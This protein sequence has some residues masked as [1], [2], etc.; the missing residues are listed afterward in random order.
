MKEPRTGRSDRAKL[1]I[2]LGKR[3]QRA[4]GGGAR[5]VGIGH[6]GGIEPRVG[7]TDTGGGVDVA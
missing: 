3:V 4:G 7:G 2:R 6:P 5:R 1:R